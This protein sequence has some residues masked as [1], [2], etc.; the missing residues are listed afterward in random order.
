LFLAC[1]ACLAG[2]KPVLLISNSQRPRDL[3]KAEQQKPPTMRIN[4][5]C[6]AANQVKPGCA[7]HAKH[8]IYGSLHWNW[9]PYPTDTRLPEEGIMKS[10]QRVIIFTLLHRHSRLDGGVFSVLFLFLPCLQTPG[11]TSAL[12][13]EGRAVIVRLPEMMILSSTSSVQLPSTG[14]A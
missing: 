10:L 13:T 8:A 5:P 1:F 12:N 14:H 6:R 2:S 4:H 11:Q 3:P 7:K 9:S